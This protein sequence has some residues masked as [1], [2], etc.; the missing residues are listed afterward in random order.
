MGKQCPV[1]PHKQRLLV[2]ATKPA[3]ANGNG[4]LDPSAKKKPK[5]KGK[6]KAKASGGPKKTPGSQKN[7]PANGG[8]GDK[9]DKKGG[10]PA[11]SSQKPE[12]TPYAT[13]KDAFM[14]TSLGRISNVSKTSYAKHS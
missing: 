13:E 2:A 3:K 7:S 12:K 8:K 4:S 6:A 14:E 9:K 1:A 5:A 11:S 10:T